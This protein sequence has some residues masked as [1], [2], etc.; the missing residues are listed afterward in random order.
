MTVDRGGD[1]R[2]P[3]LFKGRRRANSE[4]GPRERRVVIKH[5]DEEYVRVKAMADLQGVSVPRLYT[6]ALS[7]GD[8][9]AAAHMSSVYAEIVGAR[10][11]VAGALSNLNQ[12]ARSANIDGS[13][14]PAFFESTRVMLERQYERFNAVLA[15]LPD[16]EARG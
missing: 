9:V 2:R 4:G 16:D 6:R 3:R 12:I 10:R 8:A 7:A 1:E 14:D 11:G 13:F 5:T 15:K